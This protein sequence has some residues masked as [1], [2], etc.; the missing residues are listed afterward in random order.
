MNLYDLIRNNNIYLTNLSSNKGNE[1]CKVRFEI[2]EKFLT[3]PV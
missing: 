3:K 1:S 2:R